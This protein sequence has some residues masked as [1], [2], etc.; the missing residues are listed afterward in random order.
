MARGDELVLKVSADTTA[1]ASGLQPMND[2]LTGLQDGAAKTS[3]QLSSLDQIK[4]SPTIETTGVD[5][6][7]KSLTD[8]ATQAGDTEKAIGD[9][10][11]KPVELSVKDQALLAA[12]ERIKEL[13]DQMAEDIVLGADTRDAQREINSLERSVKELSDEPVDIPV[14]VDP[15]D[16]DFAF[17]SMAKLKRGVR[18]LTDSLLEV[19]DG[20]GALPDLVSAGVGSFGTL[21]ATVESFQEKQVAAGESI[22]KFGEGLGTLTGF[23]AG[24]WG[25]GIAA[26]ITLLT[27]FASSSADANQATVDLANSIDFSADAFDRDNRAKA[28][29][30][31]RENE[32]LDRAEKLGINTRLLTSAILGEKDASAALHSQLLSLRA[33]GIEPNS[34]SVSALTQDLNIFEDKLGTVNGAM[35]DARLA[36]EETAYA[37]GQTGDAADESASA[38]GRQADALT[39]HKAVWDVYTDSITKAETELGK[40]LD[41]IDLFNGK[42]ASAQKAT[43]DYQAALDA[44][45]EAIEKNG[46]ATRDG[47][48]TLDL[49]S[50]KGREN[51]DV[52]INT[53]KRIDE[54]RD[55]RLRDRTDTHESTKKI[56]DDYA[57]QRKALYDTAHQAGLSQA[58]AKAYVDKLLDIPDGVDTKVNLKDAEETQ[59]EIDELTKDRTMSVTVDLNM[60]KWNRLPRWKQ[61]A[62]SGGGNVRSVP[63]PAPA[64]PV[65]A[66][67]MFSP[68][69]YLDSTPIRY[70]LHGDVTTAVSAA[71]SA[72]NVARRTR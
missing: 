62:I 48:K 12:S 41:G 34:L 30:L 72:T 19:G 26:G 53:A 56:M 21:N 6:M 16:A 52:I 69:L 47:G 45:A 42:F 27:A 31:L 32:L 2:A 51:L 68:R 28:V 39:A 4:V 5:D 10:G 64:P 36:Q 54:L 25:V 55:A 33:E 35:D 7:Q 70:A 46:R 9:I 71:V 23:I 20:V 43:S 18:S 24:P 58:A 67:T 3:E 13:H 22:G 66:P 1:F 44:A 49:A 61:D 65:A 8:V 29:K 11:R 40:L 14:Q 37:I 63:A 57:A 17:E 50:E 60:E 38:F 15:E 59:K